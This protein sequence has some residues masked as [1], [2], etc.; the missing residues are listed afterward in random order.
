VRGEGVTGSKSR[1]SV[2][3]ARRVCQISIPQGIFIVC[4]IV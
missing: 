2:A 4:I 1:S 3:L